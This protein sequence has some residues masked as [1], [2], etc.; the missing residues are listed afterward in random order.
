MLHFLPWQENPPKKENKIL[1]N[2]V[3]KT[4]WNVKTADKKKKKNHNIGAKV[5]ASHH[6]SIYFD[7]EA[8]RESW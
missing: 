3:Q 4:E 2:F 5:T 1:R 8:Q 7:R 6:M